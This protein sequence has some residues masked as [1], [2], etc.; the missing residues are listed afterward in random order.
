MVESAP[1]DKRKEVDPS[2]VCSVEDVAK[3]FEE[4]IDR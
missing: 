2:K 4:Q 1:G 3:W